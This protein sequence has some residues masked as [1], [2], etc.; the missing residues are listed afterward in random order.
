[1]QGKIK[2]S[3]RKI[4]IS[5][6]SIALVIGGYLLLAEVTSAKNKVIVNPGDRIEIQ[7][8]VQEVIQGEIQKKIKTK[9]E[10]I[11][12]ADELLKKYPNLDPMI[13]GILEK[14][15]KTGDIPVIVSCDFNLTFGEM[16][17]SQGNGNKVGIKVTENRVCKYETGP[18]EEGIYTHFFILN[19]ERGKWEVEKFEDGSEV[20][21]ELLTKEVRKLLPALSPED[22]IKKQ[23]IEEEKIE[24]E[25]VTTLS[26]SYTY[27]RSNA[28]W[29]GSYYA[30]NPN[31]SFR[32]F[33]YSGGDCTN[34]IS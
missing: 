33:T 4:F 6:I 28:S 20:K 8:V 22:V 14:G 23:K 18:P 11:R 3:K 10:K 27:N 2:I 9:E 29:Y 30:I 7:S 32:D 34:F 21:G 19:K 15:V 12:E 31:P 24:K 17:I 16:E 13:K 26:S 1:M 5:V 25:N